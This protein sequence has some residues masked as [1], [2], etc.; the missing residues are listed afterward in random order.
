M[1]IV[2]ITI[3][4]KN[5]QLSCSDGSEEQLYG[6]ASRL[7]E[8]IVE[9][10]KE[11]STASFELLLVMAALSTQDQVHALSSRLGKLSSG[12]ENEEEEKFAETLSTIA[13]YLENLAKKIGK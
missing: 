13:Q 6:L 9:I 8:R 2:T 3:N 4:N 11:N 1:S 10:K 12:K 5:F 7:N